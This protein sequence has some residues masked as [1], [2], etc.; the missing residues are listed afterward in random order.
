MFIEQG[1]K[2]L[3]PGGRLGFITS[4]KFLKS[5]YGEKLQEHLVA[6]A[7]VEKIVDLSSLQRLGG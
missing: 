6:H 3:K 1:L 2:L 4:G 7:S 5:A